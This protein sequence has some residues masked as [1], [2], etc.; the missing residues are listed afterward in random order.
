MPDDLEVNGWAKICGAAFNIIMPKNKKEK[1]LSGFFLK[2]ILKIFM[3]IS[4][5]NPLD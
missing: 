3:A 2:E 5:I 1:I 4:N